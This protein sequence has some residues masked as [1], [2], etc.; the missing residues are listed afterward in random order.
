MSNVVAIVGR[1]NVGKSTFYNRLVGGREAITDDFSGVTRDRKYG[2]CE[3][4][5]KRFTVVDTGGFVAGSTDVFEEAIAQQVRV[6]VQE[7]AVIL[8]M[9][10]AQ[11][12]ITDLDESMA[13]LLRRTKKPVFLVVNKVDNFNNLLEA[14]EFYGMGFEEVFFIA[15]ISGSGTG[16]LLD[17]VMEHVENVEP[18]ETPLPKFAIIGR[19][20]VGKSSLVNTLL[21]EERNI[22]TP[23]A[24]TTRDP[25]HTVYNKFGKEFILIDTA[26]IRKKAKVEEDLE[27]YSVMRAIRALEEADVC[28]LVL[29]ASQGIEAQ[30]LAIFSL[31]QKRHKG[32]VILVNKWDLVEDKQT[33]TLREYEAIIKKRLQP[34]NDVPVVFISVLE[35]QRIFDALEVSLQVYENRTRKIKTSELNEYMANVVEGTPPPSVKGRYPKF[36]YITQLPSHYPMFAYFVNNPKWVRDSYKQ[37]LEN[38][39]REQFNFTGVPIELFMREK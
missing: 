16:D 13:N 38:K 39:L 10:D 31:A 23:I 21:G 26:G 2:F 8:F 30:D 1:P 25:I 14:N 33:N 4:G 34:F 7:A 28:L 19:P 18:L 3:W 36:K 29:D 12:G 9:V 27:F 20:N 5:G 17:A 6:A 22:V 15:S 11:T 24:G 32:L 37:F 35:K